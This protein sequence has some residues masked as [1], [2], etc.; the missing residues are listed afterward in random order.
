MKCV[1]KVHKRDG[2][3]AAVGSYCKKIF[4]DIYNK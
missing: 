4:I 2:H 1:M 3:D